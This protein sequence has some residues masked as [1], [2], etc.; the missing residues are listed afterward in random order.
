MPSFRI[1]IAYDGTDFVGWQRQAAGVSVQGLLEAALAELDEAAVTVVGAGRTDAGVHAL[2][3]VAAF[4][5]KRTIA[6]DAVVRALNVRLP[7]TVRVLAAEEV[8]GEFHPQFSARSK[9]YRYRI[10]IG[11]VLSPFER[12]YAWHV[13][14]PLDVA[15]MQAAA[16]LLE[17]T[18]D[19]VV[20]QASGSVVKTTVRSIMRSAV[21]ESAT[22]EDTDGN[23]GHGKP[24]QRNSVSSVGMNQFCDL[25]SSAVRG[26]V[27]TYEITGDGFLRHM[28]RTIAG[29]LVDIGRGRRPAECMRELVASRDRSLAG[30][31]APPQG[32]FLTRVEY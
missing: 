7:E 24:D 18:H 6:S 20:F 10:W 17:G 8:S 16:R 21:T 12:R 13:I 28:V 32:L 9:T 27:I 31:T 11:G 5:L 3:Q 30:P 2:G 15:A 19:F 1:T 23:G 26:H 29:T 14:G 22:A 4:T 25:R